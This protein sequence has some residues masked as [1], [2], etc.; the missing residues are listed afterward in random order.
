[1]SRVLAPFKKSWFYELRALAYYNE[2]ELEDVVQQHVVSLFSDFH[3]FPFKKAVEGNVTGI[4]KKPDMAMVRRDFKEW[5]II[6]VEMDTHRLSHVIEQIEVFVDVKYNSLDVAT[7]MRRQMQTYCQFTPTILQ[8]VSTLEEFDPTILVIVDQ[9]KEDWDKEL[10]RLG[11]ELCMFETYKSPAG[12]HI[13]RAHGR[14]PI[15]VAQEALCTWF[16]P[17]S[18]SLEIHG[19]FNFGLVKS[20][21]SLDVEFDGYLTNWLYIADNGNQY[22]RFFGTMNP[23]SAMSKYSIFSDTSGKLFLKM[24]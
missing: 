2:G 12:D 10:S 23:L 24:S 14:Y 1:M 13:Y 15:V 4:K 18:N 6:E 22:L 21:E 5:G 11:A 20:G 8:L 17:E 9:Y 16:K 7:Y 3:V 19:P